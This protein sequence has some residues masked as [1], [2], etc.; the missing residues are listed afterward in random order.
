VSAVSWRWRSAFSRSADSARHRCCGALL[1]AR[2]RGFRDAI[3]KLD[4]GLG[5]DDEEFALDAT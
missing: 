2:E 1:D 3:E 4:A 5:I